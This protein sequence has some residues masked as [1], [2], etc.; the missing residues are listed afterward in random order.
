[1]NRAGLA[2]REGHCVGV[3]TPSATAIRPGDEE[4]PAA[5]RSAGIAGYHRCSIDPPGEL[6]A[7][8]QPVVHVVA[9]IDIQQQQRP[10]RHRF[11]FVE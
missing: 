3:P 10:Q 6:V 8:E 11:G 9:Q 1:M 7:E 4:E 5:G 2:R